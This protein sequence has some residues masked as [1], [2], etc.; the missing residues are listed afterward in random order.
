MTQNIIVAIIL[1]FVAVYFIFAIKK[2]FS[3]SGTKHKCNGCSS[4]EHADSVKN[5]TKSDYLK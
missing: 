1:I 3:K 2:Y 4:C 5:T